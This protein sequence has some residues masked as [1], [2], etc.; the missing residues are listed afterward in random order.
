MYKS[1]NII[2]RFVSKNE[3]K[4]DIDVFKDIYDSLFN[5]PDNTKV[6]ILRNC[7]WFYENQENVLLSDLRKHFTN[8]GIATLETDKFIK[9][10][11]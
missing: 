10:I 3:Y 6:I 1:Y 8:K 5:V 7:L 4:F 11:K 9:I 2:N